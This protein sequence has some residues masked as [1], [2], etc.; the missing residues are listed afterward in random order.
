MKKNPQK[1]ILLP[2][3]LALIIMFLGFYQ[4]S[5][6]D[7]FQEKIVTGAI[8]GML[9]ELDPHSVYITRDRLERVTEQFEGSYEGI[10]IEFIILIDILRQC[11]KK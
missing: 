6:N 1:R 4:V 8:Q 11:L 3:K 2:V 9:S 7:S 10:G 5:A